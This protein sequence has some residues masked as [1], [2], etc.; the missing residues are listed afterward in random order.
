MQCLGHT[1]A[2]KISLFVSLFDLSPGD[3]MYSLFI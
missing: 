1:Y 3:I 2:K